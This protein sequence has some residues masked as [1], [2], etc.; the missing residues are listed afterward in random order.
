MGKPVKKKIPRKQLDSHN[1][2]ILRNI[3]NAKKVKMLKKKKDQDQ[4]NIKKTPELSGE[5][6]ELSG[7]LLSSE[8]SEITQ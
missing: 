2:E 8:K 6:L 1:L 3:L 4:N 7:E 5:L